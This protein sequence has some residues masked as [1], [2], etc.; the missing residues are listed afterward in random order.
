MHCCV[1]RCQCTAFVDQTLDMNLFVAIWYLSFNQVAAGLLC[2]TSCFPDADADDDGLTVFAVVGVVGWPP[3]TESKFFNPRIEAN[4]MAAGLSSLIESPSRLVIL[5]VSVGRAVQDSL[6]L[7]QLLFVFPAAVRLLSLF[8]VCWPGVSDASDSLS[9]NSW[10]L[11][12]RLSGH[13]QC[14]ALHWMQASLLSSWRHSFD[15]KLANWAAASAYV[16]VCGWAEQDWGQV[17]ALEKIETQIKEYKW[18][19]EENDK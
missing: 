5:S 16:F 13:S 1:T 19:R 15:F 8:L 14:S 3:L 9:G 18:H 11:L 10:R 7:L 4:R 2:T 6:L 12:L 17:R